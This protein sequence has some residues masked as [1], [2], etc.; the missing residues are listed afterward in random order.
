M[1]QC[2]GENRIDKDQEKNF[3]VPYNAGMGDYVL[4]HC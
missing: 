4:S 2:K 1:C 3:L